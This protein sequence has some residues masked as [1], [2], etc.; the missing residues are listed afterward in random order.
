MEIGGS[1]LN[2]FGRSAIEQD[3]RECAIWRRR[4]G[5]LT[6]FLIAAVTD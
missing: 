5:P 4:G 3:T 2:P 1:R 6:P